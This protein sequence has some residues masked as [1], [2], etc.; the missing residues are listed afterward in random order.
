MNLAIAK[1]N[2]WLSPSPVC[3]R[4][5]KHDWY[6]PG[7]GCCYDEVP[8]YYDDLNQMHRAESKLTAKE[9]NRYTYTVARVICGSADSS[10]IRVRVPT[11]VLMSAP[12][13]VRA[14]AYLRTVKKWIP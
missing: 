6:N 2:G 1:H 4:S 3:C 11:N 7:D 14:E 10:E 13:H 9:W 8:S 12:A 5:V